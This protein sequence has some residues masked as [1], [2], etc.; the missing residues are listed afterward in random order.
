M[1]N[2]T[3]ITIVI[4]VNEWTKLK[5]LSL[6]DG[7]EPEEHLKDAINLYYDVEQGM[8]VL[9]WL[10]KAYKWIKEKIFK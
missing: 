6:R 5:A 4:P 8:F 1:A 2:D 10:Y 7:R 9:K 3:E